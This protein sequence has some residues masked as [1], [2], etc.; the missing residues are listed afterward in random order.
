MTVLEP[1]PSIVI[2]GPVRN[3]VYR[4]GPA[5]LA[6]FRTSVWT[7]SRLD[8]STVT[9]VIPEESQVVEVVPPFLRDSTLLPSMLIRDCRRKVSYFLTFADIQEFETDSLD[10]GVRNTVEFV[11]TRGTELIDELPSSAAPYN[12]QD[13]HIGADGG[14]HT[15]RLRKGLAGRRGA[16]PVQRPFNYA[17]LDDSLTPDVLN[18]VR[19]QLLN[20][21]GGSTRTGSPRS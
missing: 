9:F 16:V 6:R 3:R 13:R 1:S 19:D 4:I 15:T 20:H 11:I 10:T 17:V 21:W 7:W 14:R 18:S 2:Q 8:D 5:E 12:R